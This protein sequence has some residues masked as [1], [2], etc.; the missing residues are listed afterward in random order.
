MPDHDTP[1]VPLTRTVAY[2]RKSRA[3]GEETVEE[4]LAK[5]ERILQDFA[6]K[7]WGAALPESRLLR[8]VQSGETIATRPVMQ[9]L[10]GMIQRKEADAV[11]VVE[12][13]RLS[14]G[15][16]V[17][18]GELSRLFLYTGCRILTPTKTWD[19]RDEYDKKFFE[20]ELMHGNDYLEYTKRI[21]SRGRERSVRDGNYIGSRTPYGY[22]RVFVDKRPTLAVVP[23]EA[24]VVRM[25]FELYAGPDPLG[26][27][28]I[29]HR[30]NELGLHSQRMDS[31]TP[32][33]VRNVIGN[34]VYIGLLRWN[35]RKEVREYRDGKIVKTRPVSGNCI[36]AE[37]RHEPIIS[38]EL[39]DRAQEAART[40]ALPSARHDRSTIVNPL[41]GLLVCASCG[42]VMA[43]K[44]CY[45]HR[46]KKPLPPI[47]L[48]TTGGKICPTRGAPYADVMQI[49]AD[50][51]SRSLAE[52]DVAEDAAPAFD[53]AEHTRAIY[54]NE[55][56]EL[57]KQQDR[58]YDF[59]ERGLYDEDTFRR[60]MTA[61]RAKIDAAEKSLSALDE[62]KKSAEQNAQFR[63]TLSRCVAALSDPAS[64]PEAINRLLKQIVLRIDYSREKSPRRKWDLTPIEMQVIFK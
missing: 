51:L 58:L 17:D 49:L 16:L 59:L 5:H 20:M 29:A 53:P 31:W 60:R 46:T 40:R 55:L 1:P 47:F 52:L 48:C 44:Q 35:A 14:R 64:T 23:A 8:E 2:L 13:Q 26:P 28:R 6:V 10:I 11:L 22:E 3:D 30:L 33:A 57:A 43:Y 56:S 19:L 39:W 21:M 32:Q 37:G 38:R 45:D 50:S 4:V 24:E 27:T 42:K 15:D 7:T 12:L 63:S 9:Q 41:S 34:P 54:E 18:V 36:M 61:L 62:N 25:I